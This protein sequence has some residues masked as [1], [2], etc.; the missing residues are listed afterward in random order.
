MQPWLTQPILQ[1]LFHVW[2]RIPQLEGRSGRIYLLYRDASQNERF[3]LNIHE[4]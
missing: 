2:N 3:T 1:V 4:T